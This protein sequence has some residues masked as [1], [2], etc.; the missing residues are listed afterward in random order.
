MEP[1]EDQNYKVLRG[2]IH[3]SHLT[4][5]KLKEQFTQWVCVFLLLIHSLTHLLSRHDSVVFNPG[6]ILASLGLLCFLK[7]QLAYL[8]CRGSSKIE[9][10]CV[11]ELIWRT[12]RGVWDTISSWSRQAKNWLGSEPASHWQ[13]GPGSSSV[14]LDNS[15][16]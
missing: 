4:L 1:L 5:E 3:K 9:H 12:W 2:G 14:Y 6:S 16:L 15:V 13:T 11:F 8:Q 7:V 10:F